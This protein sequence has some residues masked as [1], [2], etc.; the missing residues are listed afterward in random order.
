MGMI[1]RR[2]G[3]LLAAAV[4]VLVLIGGMA[5]PATEDRYGPTDQT[6][7]EIYDQQSGA[8]TAGGFRLLAAGAGMALVA[9]GHSRLRRGF[10]RS[11]FSTTGT[12][13]A[14]LF[15]LGAL[16]RLTFSEPDFS[17]GSDGRATPLSVELFDALAR[18]ADNAALVFAGLSLVGFG[19]TVLAAY[20]ERLD[21]VMVAPVQL[22][23]WL[24]S[25]VSLCGACIALTLRE[26]GNRVDTSWVRPGGP[27]TVA[28]SIGVLVGV[29]VI[30]ALIDS[31]QVDAPAP[32]ATPPAPTGPTPPGPAPGESPT[33]AP[34]PAP[35][36]GLG[37]GQAEPAM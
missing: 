16:A 3:A 6:M 12:T 30:G 25:A 20:R 26:E 10:G 31:G 24:G 4:V 23:L 14:G 11:L 35:T 18:L 34:T 7:G 19:L 9:L 13:A 21:P 33:P 27:F 28:G 29:V 15:A 17:L 8:K 22:P 2:G 37:P 36:P 1:E 32:T 5:S